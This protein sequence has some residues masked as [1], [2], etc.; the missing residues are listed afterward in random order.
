MPRT[1][2]RCKCVDI[3]GGSLTWA[4]TQIQPKHNT[5]QNSPHPLAPPPAARKPTDRPPPHRPPAARLITDLATS[6]RR[7]LTDPRRYQASAPYLATVPFC[8]MKTPCPLCVPLCS[9]FLFR[10][11]SESA[12]FKR[13]R[14]PS[15][16]V[17]SAVLTRGATL[18]PA[19]AARRPKRRHRGGGRR[20]RRRPKRGNRRG[21]GRGDRMTP[22]C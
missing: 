19:Q 22:R 18:P 2:M 10:G 1:S 3:V 4:A 5:N 20:R 14:P 13:L 7:L 15:A 8:L 12:N 9:W 6:N 11:W 17:Q 16:P 21:A